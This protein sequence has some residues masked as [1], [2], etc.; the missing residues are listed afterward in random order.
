MSQRVLYP[1]PQAVPLLPHGRRLFSAVG[2]CEVG[3]AVGSECV[4]Y[5]HK[6][7][8]SPSSTAVA[9]PLLPHVRKLG[10][11]QPCSELLTKESSE[12]CTQKPSF[13]ER[14]GT[15]LAVGDSRRVRLIG[16]AVQRRAFECNSLSQ[17]SEFSILHR[18]R[19]PSF[20]MEGGLGSCKL[21]GLSHGR[22]LWMF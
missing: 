8:S 21:V 3:S 4:R 12:Q 13:S 10:E 11:V 5:S 17:A 2:A 20:H 18:K 15:A 22:G 1:P 9:V 14:G 7:A 19:S 6:P 16:R